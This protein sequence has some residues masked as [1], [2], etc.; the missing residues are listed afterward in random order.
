MKKQI[1]LLV[2][3]LSMIGCENENVREDFP[4]MEGFYIESCGLPSV[5]IDNVKSFSTKVNDYITEYPESEEHS[6]Y[7]KRQTLR[8]AYYS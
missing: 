8:W 5:S 1:L 3:S 2:V 7:P 6:P 4:E